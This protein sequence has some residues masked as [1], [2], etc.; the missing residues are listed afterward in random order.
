MAY[1]YDRRATTETPK[2]KGVLEVGRQ[3]V[4]VP[5]G[6]GTTKDVLR[7]VLDEV[8]T[9]W[10]DQGPRDFQDL[11]TELSHTLGRTIRF[12]DIDDLP[13]RFVRDVP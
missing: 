12:K 13:R 8:T 5:R 4:R 6:Q 10:R 7:A 3:R 2:L 9:P 1:S 11:A